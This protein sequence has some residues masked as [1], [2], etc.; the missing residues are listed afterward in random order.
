MCGIVGL[1]A[2]TKTI[3]PQLGQ[4]LSKMLAEMAERGPDSTGFAL[5]RSSEQ[6]EQIKISVAQDGKAVVWQQVADGLAASCGSLIELNAYGSQAIL[7][8][9]I[10]SDD[11]SAWLNEN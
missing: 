2:K 4:Y 3:E 9:A 11:A 5:Y 7:K 10:S 1:F 6:P 8:V